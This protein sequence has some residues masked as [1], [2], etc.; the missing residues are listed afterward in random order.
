VPTL[1]HTV[2][3]FHCTRQSCVRQYRLSMEH[4]RL[5]VSESKGHTMQHTTYH[6]YNRLYKSLQYKGF[7]A[8]S[9]SF[10]F[11][12]IS[13]YPCHKDSLCFQ[14]NYVDSEVTT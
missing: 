7:I 9:T 12:R 4:N 6:N 13:S 11:H 3:V 8:P 1:G 10:V 2:F 5:C 14:C